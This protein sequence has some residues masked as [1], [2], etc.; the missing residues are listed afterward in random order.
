LECCQGQSPEK[1]PIRP[2]GLLGGTTAPTPEAGSLFSSPGMAELPKANYLSPTFPVLKWGKRRKCR[3][4]NAKT[5]AQSPARPCP[6]HIHSVVGPLSVLQAP[7]LHPH[8]VILGK[9]SL[10][11]LR[12]H[13]KAME[14][15]LW[16]VPFCNFPKK[17]VQPV[18][19]SPVPG[20]LSTEHGASY[21]HALPEPGFRIRGSGKGEGKACAQGKLWQSCPFPYPLVG[22]QHNPLLPRRT[23]ASLRTLWPTWR[24]SWNSPGCGR[25]RHWGP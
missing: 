19:L 7:M 10:A 9:Q 15:P 5:G 6:G 16:P 1:C 24:Q 14:S 20:H 11:S 17:V 4:G 13:P 12:G 8:P 3:G 18:Q 21:Q 23:H 22:N 2:P 25:Q